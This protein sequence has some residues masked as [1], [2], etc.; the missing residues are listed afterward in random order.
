MSEEV[1]EILIII[2]LS[3]IGV[4]CSYFVS[5]AISHGLNKV[6]VEV[7]SQPLDIDI[8]QKYVFVI[9]SGICIGSS[10]VSILHIATDAIIQSAFMTTGVLLEFD[11]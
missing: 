8:T 9:L 1:K 3:A 4:M 7:L 10:L 11:Y 6:S 5:P 2:G